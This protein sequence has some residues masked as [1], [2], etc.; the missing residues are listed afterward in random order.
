MTRYAMNRVG[1]AVFVIVASTLLLYFLAYAMPGDPVAA[2]AGEGSKS[3]D[4]ATRAIIRAQY[5][6]DQPFLVQY[7][8]Y[9]TSALTGDLGHTFSGRPVVEILASAMPVTFRLAVITVVI[10]AVVG[11]TVGVIVGQH[12]SGILDGSV[13][14]VTMVLIG[15]PTFVAGYL[16]Q[17]FLGVRAGLFK[18]TVSAE[19]PWH[20]LIVPGAVLALGSMAFLIRFTRSAIA[21]TSV[22]D[23]VR[24]ARA[25]GLP[26]WK[27]NLVH[28]LRNALIPLVTVIG[29]EFG[30]L[31]GGAILT[32]SIFNVP[33]FGQQVY[34][35]II[36]GAVA[37]TVSL[38]TVL[39]VIFV[40]VN[41]VVDLLYAVLNPK[42]RYD[43]HA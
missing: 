40:L 35:S 18:P 24:Q 20:E 37:P 21:E 12:R 41:L 30:A 2:L 31:L 8:R 42:V 1:Q 33:G 25:N 7:W 43:A 15:V 34:Q 4:E 19:A 6:L 23:H 13:M 32:E 27:I 17:H 36:R 10:Q 5:N 16:V 39:V 38:V 14:T 28:I 3:I 29:T 9:L 22:A 26:G 11:I